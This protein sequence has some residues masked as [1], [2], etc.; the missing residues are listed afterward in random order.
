M[1]K[2]DIELTEDEV[3]RI[4]DTFVKNIGRI[5][6]RFR[7]KKSWTQKRLAMALKKSDSQIYRYEKGDDNIKAS[8]MAHISVVLGF[9]MKEYVTEFDKDH[10]PCDST[11]PIDVKFRE[12]VKYAGDAAKKKQADKDLRGQQNLPPKPKMTFNYQKFEWEIDKSQP[13]AL[14][15]SK[16]VME[17][18]T[19]KQYTEYQQDR[20]FFVDYINNTD[21]S[22]K[23]MLIDYAYELIQDPEVMG[24][25]EKNAASFTKAIINFV[26]SDVDKSFQKR[27]MAYKSFLDAKSTNP[28][29]DI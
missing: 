3:S 14:P 5:I 18:V 1:E 23:G 16:T 22:G 9:P 17:F 25:S 27:L 21:V 8:T 20:L 24:C 19:P 2:E 13:A 26:V 12:I 10:F 28:D 11:V 15:S 4:K 6:A 7:N 29:L